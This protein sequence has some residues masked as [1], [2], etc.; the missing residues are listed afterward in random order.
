MPELILAI[1]VGTTSARAG[2]FGP[3]ATRRAMARARLTSLNPAP[4]RVEQDAEGVWRAVRGVIRRALSEAGCTGADLAAVGLTTQRASAVV[5][6]RQTGKPLSPLVIWS[7]LRGVERA[8]D[9]M[10]AGYFVSPQQSATKLEAIIRE[11]AD[12][13]TLRAQGRLAWG[14]IDSFLIWRLS[15]G[16]AHVT[17]R[18]QAWPS[19]YLNLMDLDWNRDLIDLQGLDPAMFPR[20]VDTRGPMATSGSSMLGAAVPITAD[21]ADQQSALAA[22]GPGAGVAKVSYGTSAT[23]NMSTAGLSLAGLPGLPPLIV[24]SADGQTAYCLEGMVLSA[25]SA[26]DWLRGACGLGGHAAFEALAASVADSAGAAFLPA[27]QGLGAPHPDPARRGGL[28]GLSPA[29]SRAHVARAGLEGVAFRVRE[30]A[31]HVFGLDGAAPPEV[32]NVDGGLTANETFMQIQA[33]LLGRPVRRH[34]AREAT[35][36]GAALGAGLGAGLLQAADVGAFARY[37]AVFTPAIGRDEADARFAAWQGAAHG[38]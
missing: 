19:G 29:V 32:L 8:S 21:I 9:L 15:G 26:L 25:G 37:D 22:H 16:G 38:G 7:D 13:E 31:D 18:S 35:L 28:T 10:R 12:A 14:N 33:D 6:D 4:G 27:L 11:I 3:D 1:D 23:V 34:A 17:D 30:V 2:V 5:W 24:S 36:A 20:L